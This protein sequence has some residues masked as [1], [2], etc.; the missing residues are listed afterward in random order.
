MSCGATGVATWKSTSCDALQS[1][2]PTSRKAI[3]APIS[4]RKARSWPCA[5]GAARSK[6][7]AAKAA[8]EREKT[9]A[10]RDF[11]SEPCGKYAN[12]SAPAAQKIRDAAG[13]MRGTRGSRNLPASE[14]CILLPPDLGPTHP[15]EL[16]GH[17]ASAPSAVSKSAVSFLFLADRR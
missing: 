1:V 15:T 6:S 17:V 14:P 10:I 16:V 11:D 3:P 12:T 5:R 8:A 2:L 4:R 7:A 9:V 13:W